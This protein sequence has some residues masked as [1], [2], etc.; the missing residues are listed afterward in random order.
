MNTSAPSQSDMVILAADFVRKFYDEHQDARLVF[1]NYQLAYQTASLVQQIAD[2][3]KIPSAEAEVA[4][5]AAWFI[6]LGYT[7][8]YRQPL[9]PSLQEIGR[10]FALY[11][12]PDAQRIKVVQTLQTV[13]NQQTP[14]SSEERLL[15][16]AYLIAAY[17]IDGENRSSLLKL[18]WKL[19]EHR[20][21]SKKEWLEL[22]M[23]QLLNI[24]LQKH[25]AKLTYEPQLSTQLL[26]IT[27]AIRKLEK[28]D[29]KKEE[30]KRFRYGQDPETARQAQSFFRI[31]YRNHINLSSIADN[32]ANIMIS[33]N[34]ILISV[35]ISFLS[36][37][38]AAATNPMIL[39]PVVIFLVTGLASLIFAVLSA[40]PKVT[41]LNSKKGLSKT[42]ILRNVVFFGNF[43]PLSLEDYEEAMDSV[44]R[45][46]E[47]YVGNLTRDL[48][49]LGKV[50]DKKY[51]Y[52]TAS[53]NIFM[54]GFVATVATFLWVLFK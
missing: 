51:R 42:E 32:K 23:Q 9:K 50:L 37:R 52:L 46:S 3:D 18:E 24:K 47:L 15:N 40:R 25:Y 5:L 39:L 49:Y 33:V 1:H 54:A 43:V 21:F 22:Q 36:Y 4:T 2:A 14:A 11:P 28:A 12:Y 41:T 45:D 30:K 10:F 17:L 13:E 27:K 48:Y 19:I 35:M 53:Y 8:D 16:D 34:A 20:E 7:L 29:D 6:P 26:T 44:F 31:N 38:N